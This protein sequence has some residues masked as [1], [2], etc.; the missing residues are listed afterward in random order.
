[1]AQAAAK[2]YP[3]VPLALHLDHGKDLDQI[4]ECLELGFS[5]VMIDVSE[6]DFLTNVKITKKVVKAAQHFRVAVEAEIGIMPNYKK[7]EKLDAINI[8]QAKEFVKRTGIDFLAAPVGTR[9]G[10]K[11]PE[12]TEHINFIHLK[13][14]FS[15][16]KIPLVLHGAS[17]VSFGELRRARLYGIAKVNF[18]TAI[19][20]IFDNTLRKFL[21]ADKSEEDL[22]VY[23][24]EA[25]KSVQKLVKGKIEA[26]YY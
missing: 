26:L 6:K 1:L 25:G 13:N 23:L 17:G 12:G 3:A 9:H 2:I 19:R 21:L 22:R 14:L 5:S 18:D 20:K 16:I 24:N 11:G 15:E 7:K 10:M 8:E 4:M